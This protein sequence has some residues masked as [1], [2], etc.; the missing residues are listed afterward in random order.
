LEDIDDLVKDE[1]E[2]RGKSGG[3]A[4]PKNQKADAGSFHSSENS[5]GKTFVGIVEKYFGRINVVAIHLERGIKVGDLIEIGEGEE[6]VQTIV[7]S[8]QINKLDVA[9]AS[10]GDSVGIKIDEPVK[11]GSR[12]YLISRTDN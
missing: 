11:E 10:E 3:F 2:E 9:E 8:M 12:V 7:S 1:E 4:M 5:E 6:S